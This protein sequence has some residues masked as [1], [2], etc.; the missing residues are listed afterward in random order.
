MMAFADCFWSNKTLRNIN[1]NLNRIYEAGATLLKDAMI[2]ADEEGVRKNTSLKKVTLPMSIPKAL[3][4]EIE[5]VCKKNKKGKK[6][7]RGKKGKKGKKK[8]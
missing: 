5:T 2:A 6:K 3:I 1:L 7:K 8:K 4:K